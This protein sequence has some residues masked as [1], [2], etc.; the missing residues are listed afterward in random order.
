MLYPIHDQLCQI[1]PVHSSIVQYRH[2]EEEQMLGKTIRT[3]RPP[4]PP[5]AAARTAAATTAV[6]FNVKMKS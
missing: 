3:T 5:P 4:P 1:L 2:G 6:L